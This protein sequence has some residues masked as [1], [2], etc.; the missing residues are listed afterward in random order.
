[1]DIIRR[2]VQLTL[3]VA[4]VWGQLL[5]PSA[6]QETAPPAVFKPEEIDQLVA[7][8]ALYPDPLLAQIFMASTYP[9]EIVQAA[10]WSKDNPNLKDKAL[11]DALQQQ[12]WDPSVK[13][14]TAF[15]QVLVMMNEQ[16]DWTQKLG[17]AFL[18]QQKD[19]MAG[20]QRLRAKANAEG[21]LKTTPEQ[22]VVV[23]TVQAP[24]QQN[25]TV[26]QAPSSTQVDHDRACRPPGRLRAHV[27]P[28]PG[29]RGVAG[30]SLSTALLLSARLRRDRFALIVRRRY[31]GGRRR[32]G[33]L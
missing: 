14:L 7:P 3:A 10:R 26:Q 20:V 19:V 25:V 1:M 15:P 27:Q 17:D 13:S 28:H 4:F 32:V 23:E 22:K 33:K 8:I 16:L 31:G 18:A 9:L 5:P 24:A 6:A 11:E 2:T 30:P 12:S 21:N 29:V